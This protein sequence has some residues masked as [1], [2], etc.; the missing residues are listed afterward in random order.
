MKTRRALALANNLLNDFPVLLLEGPRSVGK[1]TLLQEVADIRDGQIIDLDD[2]PTRDAV[3]ADPSLAVSGGQLICVD[4]Y[5]KVPTILDAIKT[6]LNKKTEPGRFVLTGSAR[7]DA[8]PAAAQAL[9]GRLETLTV[10][11]LSQGEQQ[12]NHEDF[13]EIAM[14]DPLAVVTTARSSTD[15]ADYIDR[16]CRGGFPLA[17]ATSSDTA[18]RRWIRSYVKQTLERDVRELSKLRQSQKLSALLGRLAGQTAQVLN[19]DKAAQAVGL[20]PITAESYLSLLEKVF[21]VYRLESWGKTLI[22]RT[23]T[24]PKLHVLDSGVAAVLLRLTPE[25]LSALDATANIEFGHLVETF[26][27]GELRKQASWLEAVA[28]LGHWR[29]RDGD[30]VDLVIEREDGYI[31]G[32]EIKAGPRVKSEELKGLRKLRDATGDLFVGGFALHLGERSYTFED[33][34]HVV[35]LDRIWH[36]NS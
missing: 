24:K 28:G 29:S 27:V 8:L 26:A 16:I 3:A 14:A 33:R 2:L 5:L 4:E 7:H 19:V 22:A 23:I 21:L 20:H 10:Y 9:T 13:L 17:L 6:E 30:E 31:I 34:I 18:Q 25:K 1:S 15:R 32:F 36:P 35:P 11:P 12:G